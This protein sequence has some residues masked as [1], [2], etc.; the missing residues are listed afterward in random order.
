MRASFFVLLFLGFISIEGKVTSQMRSFSGPRGGLGSPSFPDQYPNEFQDT[1]IIQLGSGYTTD[2]IIHLDFLVFQLENLYDTVDIFDG[3]STDPADNIA[4]LTGNM[5][6]RTYQ[7]DGPVLTILF[8]TDLTG[9]R[10][11]FYVRWTAVKKGESYSAPK[12]CDNLIIS[13]NTGYG[14]IYSPGYVGNYPDS[15]SCSWTL[16]AGVAQK[17]LLIFYAY[18]TEDCYDVLSFYDGSIINANKRSKGMCGDIV[19]PTTEAAFVLS[20]GSKFSLVFTSDMTKNYAGFTAVFRYVSASET[21][22]GDFNRM[23][24]TPSKIDRHPKMIKPPKTP[25]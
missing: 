11:G 8:K 24:W 6:G 19:N 3:N 25:L 7:S 12:T 2:Y 1:A 22:N 9:Q 5:T 17:V 4:K 14:L 10:D 18:E 13:E 21:I 16:E 20:T 15:I 23:D